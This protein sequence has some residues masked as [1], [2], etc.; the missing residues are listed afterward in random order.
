MEAYEGEYA[1][2]VAIKLLNNN[3]ESSD[4]SSDKLSDLRDFQ[5]EA[6]IMKNLRH[7]NIVRIL[8]FTEQPLLIIMENMTNG[9]LL[10]YLKFKRFDLKEVHLLNFSKNIASV[11]YNYL[12]MCYL[13]Y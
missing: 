6:K 5:R 8:G 12:L 3:Y 7:D 11:S 10:N 13:C 2:P 4:E 9:S 1:T